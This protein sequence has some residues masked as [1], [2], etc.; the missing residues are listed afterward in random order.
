MIMPTRAG[1]TQYVAINLCND[2]IDPDVADDTC[3][4]TA[5][6]QADRALILRLKDRETFES[7]LSSLP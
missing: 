3:R 7:T 2:I 4:S 5:I 6:V 1:V